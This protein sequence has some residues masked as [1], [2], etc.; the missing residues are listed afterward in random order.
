LAEPQA[1]VCEV[2]SQVIPVGQSES[3]AQPH[4]PFIQRWPMAAPVQSIQ[5]PPDVPQLVALVPVEQ[6]PPP[7]Q[8]LPQLPSPGWPQLDVQTPAV[9]VGVW[10]AHLA[11]AAPP[12]PQLVLLWSAGIKH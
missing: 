2:L 5:P 4:A 9:Q 10:P 6:C 12:L 7:Q 11:H 3:D 1:Q 8:P